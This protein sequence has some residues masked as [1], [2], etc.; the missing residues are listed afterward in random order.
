M[1]QW[2]PPGRE[3]AAHAPHLNGLL[4]S[5]E[6]VAHFRRIFFLADRAWLEQRAG[7]GC[8]H[9]RDGAHVLLDPVS[10]EVGTWAVALGGPPK[11]LGALLRELSPPWSAHGGLTVEA[12]DHPEVQSV[13][14]DL[15]F[16][17]PGTDDSYVVVE[18]VV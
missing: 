17:P 7:Q 5:R 16:Q 2:T 13:L 4:V 18:S 10:P 6:G 11:A 9:A 1:P 12:T 14:D 8:W 3:P 15:G